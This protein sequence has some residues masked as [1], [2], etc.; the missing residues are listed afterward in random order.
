MFKWNIINLNLSILCLSQFQFRWWTQKRQKLVRTV[1]LIGCHLFHRIR[2]AKTNKVNN[3]IMNINLIGMEF[4]FFKPKHSFIWTN[5]SSN[6]RKFDHVRAVLI[7]KTKP[8]F[9]LVKLAYKKFQVESLKDALPRRNVWETNCSFMFF[10]MF[11]WFNENSDVAFVFVDIRSRR[12]FAH[13]HFSHETIQ[14]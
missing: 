3:R 11:I 13:E 14:K 4:S 6:M 8:F 7:L 9:F 1:G 2:D 10:S 12:N 5:I